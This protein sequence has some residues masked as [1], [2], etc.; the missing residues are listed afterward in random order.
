M[1]YLHQEPL[2]KIAR[3]DA[4]ILKRIGANRKLIL[5]L[6]AGRF[7]NKRPARIRR[8]HKKQFR[9]THQEVSGR[10]VWTWQPRE[11]VPAKTILYIHGGAYVHNLLRVH[12]H[13]IGELCRLTGSRLVIPD[14]PLAPEHHFA[15]AYDFLDEVT[16]PILPEAMEGVIFMGDSAG[17]GLALGYAQQL[18]DAGARLPEQL[19]LYSPWLDVTMSDPLSREVQGVDILLKISGL[20]QAGLAWAGGADPKDPRISP[21]FGSL[22]SLPPISFFSSTNDILIADAYRLQK[23]LDTVGVKYHFFEYPEMFHGWMAIVSMPEAQAVLRQ[24]ATLIQSPGI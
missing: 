8:K 14:Y 3:R 24:T 20:T 9:I 19:I 21:L 1:H 22:E 13:L 16:R 15:D 10:K 2:S 7:V 23:Q 6:Q 11:K 17:A 12:W 4:Y 18:R 5:E